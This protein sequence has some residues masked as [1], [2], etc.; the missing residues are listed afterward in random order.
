MLSKKEEYKLDIRKIER[1][2]E[3]IEKADAIIIGAGA[4][5]STAAGFSYTGERF[6]KYFKDFA[7][8]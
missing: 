4:G 7:D 5:L 1:L 3:E 8:K 6:Q 2:R